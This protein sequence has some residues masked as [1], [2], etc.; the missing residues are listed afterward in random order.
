MGTHVLDIRTLH[1]HNTDCELFSHC[2]KCTTTGDQKGGLVIFIVNNGS[3][4]VNFTTKLLGM[5][6]KNLEVQPYIFT[7]TSEDSS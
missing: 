5:S 7:S 3:S 2:S 1:Y 6:F 4:P